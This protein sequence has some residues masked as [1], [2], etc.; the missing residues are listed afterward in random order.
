MF[1]KSI[2]YFKLSDEIF[3]ILMKDSRDTSS[4]VA[5]YR[6]RHDGQISRS[7]H[8][9]YNIIDIKIDGNILFF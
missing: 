8:C 2:L 4:I 3:R 1:H 6:W 9:I 7:H 5:S